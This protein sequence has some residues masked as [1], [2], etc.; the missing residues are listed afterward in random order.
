MAGTHWTALRDVLPAYQRIM[1]VSVGSGR[2]TSFWHD[3]WLAEGPLAELLLAIYNN[4][5]GRAMS[6]HDVMEAGLHNLLQHRLTPQAATELQHPEDLLQNV[7]L[8]DSPDQ[9][10][11]FFQGNGHRLKSGIIYRASTRGDHVCASFTFVWCNFAPPQVKF[12]IWLLTQDRIQCRSSLLCKNIVDDA[13]CAICGEAVETADHIVLG[14]RF[15][16][17]FWTRIGW[18]PTDIAEVKQLWLSQA[19]PRIHKDVAH[20]FILLCCWEIWKHR[21]DVIFKGLPPSVDR[22]TTACRQ[23]VCS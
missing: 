19:P 9:R 20:P 16:H 12:F 7:S 3:T 14:C 2:D 15:V 6:V 17:S 1:T 22:L 4:F 23:S 11:S 10:E 8:D 13:N 18:V 21:N 5:H